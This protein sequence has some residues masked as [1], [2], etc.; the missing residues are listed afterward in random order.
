MKKKIHVFCLK[1][2][3]CSLIKKR[4]TN[5]DYIVTCS[6]ADN[7]REELFDTLNKNLDCI[8]IDRDIKTEI[9]ESIKRYFKDKPII[10][11]PSL[12]SD[13]QSEHDVKNI[14]EPLRLSEL[15]DTLDGIFAVK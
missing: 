10:C 12:D 8:I 9:K 5:T 4:F 7:I 3:I 2:P 6:N 13:V 11:L 1:P 15:A 14:S